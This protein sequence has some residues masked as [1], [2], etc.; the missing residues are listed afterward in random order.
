MHPVDEFCNQWVSP[1]TPS[2]PRRYLKKTNTSAK[3]ESLQPFC[4]LFSHWHVK[5]SSSKR[6]AL[7]GDNYVIGPK[8]IL[9]AGA[10]VHLSARKFCTGWS[11]EGV[12][13]PLTCRRRHG[14]SQPSSSL[15]GV[16]TLHADRIG[17]GPC[18]THAFKWQDRIAC[19]ADSKHGFTTSFLQLLGERCRKARLVV[20][21]SGC[22]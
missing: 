6:I 14:S 8:N 19:M 3:F 7:K 10:S 4:F 11:R 22:R 2:L 13:F 15:V 9:F 17:T 21:Q 5:G 12:K 16:A 20:C 18:F 1:L